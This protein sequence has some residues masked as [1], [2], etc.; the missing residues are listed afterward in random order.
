VFLTV[1]SLEEQDLSVDAEE[2]GRWVDGEPFAS[3]ETVGILERVSA[4]QRKA[5][6]T[7]EEHSLCLSNHLEGTGGN[8]QQNHQPQAALEA[9][10]CQL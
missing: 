8:H 3:L 4:L 10:H 9:L 6:T 2:G 7:H 5:L 1:G